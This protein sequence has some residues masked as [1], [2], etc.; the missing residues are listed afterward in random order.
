MEIITLK[1]QGMTC[2]H[3]KANVE[4]NITT[5]VGIEKVYAD[6]KNNSVKINGNGIDLQKVKKT[7]ESLG[8][9]CKE[10]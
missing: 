1:V 5:L 7:I 6:I 3:C 8:Y 2:N 10:K 9:T 4:K